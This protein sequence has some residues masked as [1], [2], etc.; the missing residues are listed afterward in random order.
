MGTYQSNDVYIFD[1]GKEETRT[2]K[3][4]RAREIIKHATEMRKK[5]IYLI[6]AGNMGYSLGY[7]TQDSPL[8]IHALIDENKRMRIILK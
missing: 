5:D 4:L 3:D 8:R 1:G 6:T 2:L 7:F